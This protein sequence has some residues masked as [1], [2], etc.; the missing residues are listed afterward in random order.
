MF[1]DDPIIGI[2]RNRAAGS[3]SNQSRTAPAAQT[4]ILRH[5][6]DQ[7]APS[8]ALGAKPSASI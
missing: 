8:P 7:C 4:M 2:V 6:D 3:Q 1:D 5:R